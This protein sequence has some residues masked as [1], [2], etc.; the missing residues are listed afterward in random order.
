MFFRI[1]LF[2]WTA[3]GVSA[4]LL[5]GLPSF[6]HE[7]AQVGDGGGVRSVFLVL[8]QNAVEVTINLEFFRDDGTPLTLTI[9]ETTASRFE[10]KA[11]AG[12]T[13]RLKTAGSSA[14]AQ[15]GW[16]RLTS[17]GGVGAQLLFE[18]VVNG[19]LVTQAAVEST[20]PIRVFDLFMRAV[21]GTNS[22]V[23][24]A[25][26]TDVNAIN[27][28]LTL[29]NAQGQDVAT[30]T[31]QIASDGHLA[32]FIT[33]LFPEVGEIDGSLHGEASGP[34]TVIALQQTGAVLGTLPFVGSF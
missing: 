27:V 15:T 5:A 1:F 8:N 21:G 16:A 9:G 24:L 23:A 11:A 7:F 6:T 3:V 25:N 28:R 2:G 10:F 17:T 22:G 19:S 4:T 12:G 20:G 32:Q 31:V 30:K 13:L 14:V 26:L 33:E 29:R 34:V 18:I